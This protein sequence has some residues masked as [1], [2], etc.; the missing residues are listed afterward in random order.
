MVWQKWWQDLEGFYHITS[1][2]RK[3]QDINIGAQ[4]PLFIQSRKQAHVIVLLRIS[5]S[6]SI[7]IN[8][9][10]KTID[11]TKDLFPM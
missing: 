9:N 5:M 2:I 8:P 6:L 11:I 3:Q 7:S 4:Y 10:L 1:D